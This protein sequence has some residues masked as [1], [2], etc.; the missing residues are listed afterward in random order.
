MPKRVT[1]QDVARQAGVSHQTVSRVINGKPDVAPETR[2]RVQQI[3]DRLGYRPSSVA[4][5]LVS[6]RTRT[7]SLI[8]S[9][10]DEDFY[11]QVMAGAEEEARHHG[12]VFLL[13]IVEP[14][15]RPDSEEW[16]AVSER[17][18]D[19]IFV[20]SPE[21]SHRAY[22]DWLIEQGIPVVAVAHPPQS[23]LITLNVDNVEGGYMATH[24]LV[25]QGHRRIGT[26]S[27]VD[28]GRTT[29]YQRALEEAGLPFEPE[30]IQGGD[31][32]YQSGF[33]A[34]QRL[35][36]IAPDL[37]AVFAQNDQMA[38]GAIQA[39]R[40]AHLRVPEDIAVVGFDDIPAA[41]FACPPLTTVRQPMREIGR[42]A[43]R[44]LLERIRHP[45]MDRKEIVFRTQFIRRASA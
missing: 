41:A 38:I 12:Y 30:L 44:M 11:V 2:D 39:L 9:S 27:G 37:T 34:M 17:Q 3:I 28:N 26:I 33:D 43:V 45:V 22:I 7:L 40:E 1:I 10:L 35:L 24:Y 14:D 20:A 32:S 21:L 13:S 29:G 15:A 18:V 31:W 25:S 8:S 42:I 5:S 16:R 36:R 6:Q 19:G 23:G 4:R